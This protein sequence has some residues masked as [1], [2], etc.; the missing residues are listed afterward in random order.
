[1]D[2]F[3]VQ[4]GTLLDKPDLLSLQFPNEHSLHWYVK[5][6]L[7]QLLY[8][9]HAAEHNDLTSF[10]F[11]VGSLLDVQSCYESPFFI[12]REPETG[13]NMYTVAYQVDDGGKEVLIALGRGAGLAGSYP[14]CQ[15]CTN[16]SA[17]G[18]LVGFRAEV[19]GTI[20]SDGVPPILTVSMAFVSNGRAASEICMAFTQPMTN[21]PTV[22]SSLP[23]PVT[24]SPIQTTS[25]P[26]TPTEPVPLSEAPLATPSVANPTTVMPSIS[27]LLTSPMPTVQPVDATSL[28]PSD[29]PVPT[30]SLRL[31]SSSSPSNAP[32]AMP[33]MAPSGGFEPPVGSENVSIPASA[34]LPMTIVIGSQSRIPHFVVIS[35][36]SLLSFA[37][38]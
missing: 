11:N 19:Y 14:A 31:N 3:C 32:T 30:V 37:L 25:T 23:A 12:L 28:P 2:Q 21:S 26:V 6:I 7:L 35:V 20:T 17:T 29:V 4:L 8:V 18:L 1:M 22:A 38:F 33:F 36:I 27:P 16:T 34:A 9:V 5:N 13:S 15:T 10:R 24:I